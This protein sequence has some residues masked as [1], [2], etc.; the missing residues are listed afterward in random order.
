MD[1]F[2]IFQV[3]IFSFH[4]NASSSYSRCFTVALSSYQS[5]ITSCLI[6]GVFGLAVY[7]ILL[8][9]TDLA[10]KS[11][12]WNKYRL[13]K[14]LPYT[15]YLDFILDRPLDNFYVQVLNAECISGLFGLVLAQYLCCMLY[16]FIGWLKAHKYLV[17]P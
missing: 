4:L 2:H 17:S 13:K 12:V 10:L 9:Y 5:V 6:T 1:L 11:I 15:K 16:D 14:H 8:N 3:Q 7:V